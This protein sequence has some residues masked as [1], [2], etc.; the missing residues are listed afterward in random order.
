MLTSQDIA[1]IYHA[2]S[3]RVLATLIRLL[4]DFDLAEEALAE[5][6]VAAAES[7]PRDGLPE[8]P[9]AWLISTG[10]FKVID[11]LRRRAKLETLHPEVERRR[12][13][14]TRLNDE[15]SAVEIEDDRLRLI[16]TCCH[17][18]IDPQIQIA[19]TLRE[20][21]GLTTEEIAAAFLVPPATLA[22][23]IVRG[24]AKI[25]DAGIPYQ[26]PAREELP[27]RRESVL[28]VCYLVFNE[29]YAA[30]TGTTHT[31]PDLS[32]EAIRLARLLA[33]LSPDAEVW[34]LLALMLFHESRRPARCGE[35]GDLILL[36]EQDRSRWDRGLIAEARN[37][38]DRALASG[39]VG[40]YTIQAAISAV[41]AA[42]ASFAATDWTAIVAWYEL[43]AQAHPS[44]VVDL[45]R[46][47]AVAM[48]DGPVAGLVLV[49]RLAETKEL[50][51]Y[52]LFHAARA[53]LLRRLDR[54][55]EAVTAYR[56]A[57]RLAKQEPERRYLAR[58]IRELASQPHGEL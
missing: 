9:R 38:L 19:L 43:L 2:E 46:A 16:F 23:R 17:P 21:C 52:H 47:V 34:G 26:I 29:G 45:N 5:A 28:A 53:D 24:K 31:R 41:H 54:H 40:P 14:I 48:R 56:E 39:E 57:W 3:R 7:W 30:S 42:A 22:Q 35:T 55:E 51:S 8:Q 37:W 1:A 25:R 11:G 4:G 15:R 12:D 50:M 27:T 32:R 58:R 33:E 44:P 6:F 36:E 13:A 49:D 10:R 18:A 20:V